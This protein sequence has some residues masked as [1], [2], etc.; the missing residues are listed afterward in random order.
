MFWTV[1]T[2]LEMVRVAPTKKSRIQ[3]PLEGCLSVS[4]AW[5]R[6]P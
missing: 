5:V 4:L 6:P 3:M 1:A 2:R